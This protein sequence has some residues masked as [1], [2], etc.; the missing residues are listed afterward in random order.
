MPVIE[1]AER[2]QANLSHMVA[3][4]LKKKTCDSRPGTQLEPTCFGDTAIVCT[5]D[6]PP[7]LSPG[8]NNMHSRLSSM[9]QLPQHMKH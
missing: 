7:K 1:I 8:S 4:P 9:L 2:K 3:F 6:G 5:S